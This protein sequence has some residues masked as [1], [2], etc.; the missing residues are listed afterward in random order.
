MDEDSDPFGAPADPFGAPADPFAAP[1]NDPF[2]AP[3]SDPFSAPAASDPFAAS[4]DDPFSQPSAEE[5]EVDAEE[6]ERNRLRDAEYQARMQALYE[7]EEAE[8]VEKDSRRNTAT[9]QLSEWLQNRN[10]AI[11]TR[12]KANADEEEV[13]REQKSKRNEKSWQTVVEMIDFKEQTDSK[14]RTRL[15]SVLLAKKSEG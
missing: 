12:K 1:S 8:R 14:D 10:K 15:R 11:E 5:A 13:F 9:S 3:S 2:A 7:R 6:M 4:R